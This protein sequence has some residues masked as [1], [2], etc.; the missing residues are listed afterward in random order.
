MA[1]VFPLQGSALELPKRLRPPG[2]AKPVPMAAAA[3][4]MCVHHAHLWGSCVL[5]T[6]R[7]QTDKHALL[8]GTESS[9]KQNTWSIYKLISRCFLS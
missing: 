1:N 7:T 8:R 9:G 3:L 5:D 4:G 2:E 6:G